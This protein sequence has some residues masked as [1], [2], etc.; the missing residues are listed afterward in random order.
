MS[1]ED[2]TGDKSKF[3]QVIARHVPSRNK[4]LIEPVLTKI[5]EVIW[6]YVTQLVKITVFFVTSRVGKKYSAHSFLA[7]RELT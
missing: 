6:H 5:L 4:Q 3:G 7:I 2:L 1:D